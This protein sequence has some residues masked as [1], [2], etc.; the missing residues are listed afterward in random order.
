MQQPLQQPSLHQ[1]E[2]P[3]RFS[4][5]GWAR[6]LTLRERAAARRA[7]APAAAP[8]SS[9]DAAR[10]ERRLEHW[11]AQNPFRQDGYLD[12]RLALEG[13]RVDDLAALLGEA[14]ETTAAR[15]AARPP[16]LVQLERAWSTTP[17]VPFPLS[18]ELLA[19][20]PQSNFLW[21]V[22]PL[23]DSAY[24]DL[25][26]GL[27]EIARRFPSPPFDPATVGRL[28]AANLPRPLVLLATRT[29]VLEL[30]LA[31]HAG[32]LSGATPEER[33]QSFIAT[34][35]DPEV[36]LG[37]LRQYPVLA[38]QLVETVSRW[39]EYSLEI[40]VHLAVDAPRLRALFAP[41]G[42][43][44]R[45]SELQTGQGDSHRGRR[46]V[47]LLRFDSGLGLVYKPRSLALDTA[48]QKLLDWT[49]ERGFTPGFRSL[50]VLAV[51]G[52]GWVERVAAAPCASGA[53]VE[54]FYLR[55]GG[56]LALLYA[57]S[58]IDMHHEN[59]I[60]VG[61]HPILV[62]LEAL[63]H[64]LD[65]TLGQAAGEP[66]SPDTVQRIGF[67]PMG[68]WGAARAGG[69]GIDFSG[70]GARDGQVL[71]RPMLQ[72]ADSGT[73][74]MRFFRAAVAIPVGDHR[75]T[76]DGAPVE[77]A[78]YTGPIVAGFQRMARLLAVHR[79]EL[80]SPAG[81]LAAFNQAPV[82]FLVRKTLAYANLAFEGQ[83]PYVLGDALD[84]DR[85]LDHLWSA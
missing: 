6:A 38:R 19:R 68:D 31:G 2:E 50:R 79:A 52:H 23:L 74:Q 61:E 33:F 82:R 1:V 49:A 64:P 37:I 24:A 53:E 30:S 75:P 18:S 56:Y 84:R 16:W 51:D 8:L 70:L 34:L 42:D 54:R 55:Q 46:S 7:G 41:D 67:L 80:L 3:D 20:S 28:L 76:L 9:E 29:L 25:C 62:D 83:H 4:L 17:A 27:S 14:P 58:A 44:G 11:R 77:L 63:F 71:P 73:D 15:A 35:R 78:A 21:V 48:F 43:L 60:A 36:A 40:L 66:A 81:P 10:A 32:R 59:L 47:A 69:P 45:L 57:L 65:E 12:R 85:H 72:I 13:L 26:A 39:V 22:R 5:S